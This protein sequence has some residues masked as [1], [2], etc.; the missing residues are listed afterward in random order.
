MPVMSQI[1]WLGI[2]EI[3]P[4]DRTFATSLPWLPMDT[5]VESV[6]RVGVLTPLRISAGGAGKKRI[7][8]G[9]RRHEAARR[10]G[11]AA[12]PALFASATEAKEL[13]IEALL[14]NLATRGLHDLEKAHAL[15]K[16]H[17]EFG[18]GEQSLID[19][20]LPLLGIRAD[21]FH[22]NYYLSLAR[23]P[24]TLGRALTEGLEAEIALKLLS[25][26]EEGQLFFLAKVKS[27]SLGKNRQKELFVL[28][29]ELRSQPAS[30]HSSLTDIWDGSGAAEI[31]SEERLSPS[32]RL[33]G[34]LIRLQAARFPRISEYEERYNALK[35]A[36]RIPPEIQFHAPRYF[37]GDRL[38]VAFAFRTPGELRRVADKLREM[39]DR[40]ELEEIFKLL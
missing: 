33:Q 2:D 37:E 18:L 23:L 22:F 12:L 29:D 39:S 8:S 9:F 7:V 30:P 27:F 13:F 19:E 17:A 5:L 31:E 35:S 6:R 4:Q 26:E 38:N 24:E 20:F 10:L 32:E 14:D 34:I 28:L 16:L 1:Q 36:L 3:D 25:W 15:W 21:R 11:L 40:E